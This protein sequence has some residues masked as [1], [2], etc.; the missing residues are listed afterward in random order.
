MAN[1]KFRVKQDP[2]IEEITEALP[3]A[4]CGAVVLEV[5]LL[6]RRL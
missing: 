3:G 5:V 2:R 1:K 6:L 4:N